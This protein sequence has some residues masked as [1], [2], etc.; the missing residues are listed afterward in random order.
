MQPKVL[1]VRGLPGSG[2]TFYANNTLAR[3][4]KCKV[5]EA[6]QYMV[7]DEGLYQYDA[8]KLSGAHQKC[9]DAGIQELSNGAEHIVFANT[10]VK[11]FDFESYLQKLADTFDSLDAQLY[12]T[13][14][15]GESIH[16]VPLH[17]IQRMKEYFLSNADIIK[18]FEPKYPNIRFFDLEAR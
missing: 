14:Y 5:F 17:K 18:L 12:V 11:H 10:F 4:L 13:T 6:D 16:R 7:N 9:L 2:K 1:F 3:Q 15:P 8:S